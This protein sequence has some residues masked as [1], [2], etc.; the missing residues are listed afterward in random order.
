MHD[1]DAFEDNPGDTVFRD[2]IMLALAGFISMVILLLPHV[3][4]PNKAQAAAN[5]PGN[6]MVEI[7]WPDDIDVDVDL[8][9]KAPDDVPVGYS[10]KSGRIFNL[11][12]DDLGRIADA[13]RLNYE[14]SYS[15]GVTAGEYVVNLHM[16]RNVAAIWP[17]PVRVVTSV[18][19]PHRNESRQILA[20]EVSLE[21]TGQELTVYRFR[22]TED[23][24]LVAGSVNSLPKPLRSGSKS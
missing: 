1:L 20:T 3:N 16:Y 17:V 2:M 24:D 12:R 15:R 6:V 9:V 7:V 18:K 11:L 5:M 23:G 21:R 14:V 4:P 19:L 22:L 8:W 13:T 10:N